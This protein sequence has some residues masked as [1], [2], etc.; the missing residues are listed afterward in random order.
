MS[1]TEEITPVVLPGDIIKIHNQNNLRLGVGVMQEEKGVTALRCGVLRRT[2]Y[3]GSSEARPLLWIDST[4]KRYTPQVDDQVVGTIVEKYAEYYKVDIGCAQP[5][6]LS[7]IAFEGATRKNKPNL[8]VGQLIYCRVEVANKFM[9]VELSCISPH[10]KKDWVTGE[11]LYGELKGG[12]VIPVSIRL[13]HEL[14]NETCDVFDIIG[15]K[16]KFEVSVGVNGLVWINS[17][18]VRHTVIITNI[19]SQVNRNSSTNVEAL[20]ERALAAIAKAE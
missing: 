4:S 19:L 17:D 13:A 7:G 20:L 14:M 2:G 6:L 1:K 15:R 16:L 18:S 3:A 8:D 9:E 12:M 11:S 10:F 5:A